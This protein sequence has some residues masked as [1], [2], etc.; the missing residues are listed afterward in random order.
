[1]T[2]CLNPAE[3]LGVFTMMAKD[4]VTAA[5]GEKHAAR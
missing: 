4:R 3:F 2:S 5:N 1:V